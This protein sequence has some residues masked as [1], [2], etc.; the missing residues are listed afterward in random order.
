MCADYQ[1]LVADSGILGRGVQG[2]DGRDGVVSC[3]AGNGCV[4]WFRRGFGWG[5][6]PAAAGASVCVVGGH[7]CWVGDEGEGLVSVVRRSGIDGRKAARCVL[8]GYGGGRRRRRFATGN[9]GSS[10]KLERNGCHMPELRSA[11]LMGSLRK[12]VMSCWKQV[13]ERSLRRPWCQIWAKVNA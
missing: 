9:E 10:R 13:G 5:G 11:S 8:G 7:G 12:G 1:V 4:F 6:G 2:M 3:Y